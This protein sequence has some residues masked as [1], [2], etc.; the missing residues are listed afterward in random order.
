MDDDNNIIQFG[1]IQGGKETKDE[2][3]F[4]ANPYVLEDIDG[5]EWGASG[6]LIFTTHHVC[7]MENT[8]KGPVPGVMLPLSRL[9]VAEL[10]TED[11]EVT[12]H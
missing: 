8:P 12:I 4:P 1:S 11:E 10:A 9:K 6:Y 3:D 7:I 5:N 2:D